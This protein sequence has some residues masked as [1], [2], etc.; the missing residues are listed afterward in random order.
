LTTVLSFLALSLGWAPFALAQVDVT[1]SAG[2]PATSYTTLKGA[3]DAINLGTHQG[4]IGI[5][6]TGST[7]ETAPAVLNAS[8]GASSYSAITIT[9]SGGAARTI[10]G[11]IVAGS[12]L[13][14]FNGA[15]NVTINGLNSGGNSL[16]IVNTTVSATSGTSTIRFIGGA[17]GNTIT[18]ANIQ[19]AGTSSVG[20]NGA[21]IFFSTDVNTANGN[22]NNTISNNNIGPVG[23]DLPTKAIL[24]NGSTTTTAIGNSGNIITNNN[25]FDFFG[26]ATTSSGVATNNGC[27]TWSI[28]NNRFYQTGTRT[29]STGGNHRVIDISG[30][31][32]TSGAQGFTI[33]GNIIGYASATQTG[34][35]TL[36]GSTGK[37]QGVVFNGI[38]AA[39]V[40]NVNANT[41]AS[42]SLSG[43]TSSGTSTSSPMIGIFI[44]SGLANTNNNIIGSQ[45]STGSLTFSTSTTT[46]TD[47]YGIYNF[48]IDSW[49]A[50]GNTIGGISVTNA[51][52]SGT[53]IIYGMRANT[54]T[55]VAFNSTSN[56]VGGAVA[57]SIQL[58]ATGI[59]SQVIG[60]QTS[61]AAANFSLN[62]IRNLTT[63]IGTGTS[64]AGS[65][66][67]INVTTTTPNHT[68][69]RNTISDLT[70]TNTTAA[71]VVTGIQFTGAAA[72]VVERNLITG[73]TVTTTSTAAE[74][75]GIRV[76]GG[77][78]VYRNNMIILG[79]GIANAIGTGST[80]GGV[81]GIN[82]PL[83]T[84][85]F[86]HNSV[87]IGGA[88]TAGAG[89][90]FAF[91][92]SQ[93]VN[94]RSFRNNIFLNGRSN[95]GATG[96]NYAVR[97]GGSGANPAGLTT[98]NNVYFANG[99]G[100]V[101][102]FYNLIDVANLAGWQAAI[103]QDAN[104]FEA[105]PLYLSTTDLRLQAGS[106][107]LDQAAN[108]AVTNDFEGDSRPG[109]NAAFDIGADERDGIPPAA[110]DLQ[111]TAFIDPSNGGSKLAGASFSPQASFTN[112]GTLG[113]T[114]VL[115]LFNLHSF[116]DTPRQTCERP[117]IL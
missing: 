37:F 31:A 16:T 48:G 19:G 11:A 62:T 50:S 36:T 3:F 99:T 72:N 39:T 66:I 10:S 90:S 22:D 103:A 116:G 56:T 55:S 108:L 83:G 57:N 80:T 87:F 85:S 82:A 41:V 101:F 35:Y 106:P 91:N 107:A 23:T 58:N 71:S 4:V 49:T 96:K 59:S 64:T 109:A 34:T 43:V 74:V 6:V 26:A 14:D 30:T 76:A 70:N 79:A 97:M 42:I 104:S 61:N 117:P 46:A 102:G 24:G 17:T 40:S 115:C 100:A 60:M 94:S 111:A 53:Q 1:A 12:P 67:G 7:T 78:T 73:L 98:N 112:N 44:A 114:N 68:L 113:Q 110:N 33:T 27:N 75:N 20:T 65:V 77:T 105:N 28:T 92:S 18:N 29:W 9:P 8:L 2:T 13:I 88:P 25:I 93:T 15:D 45:A 32:A 38:N 51:A 69:S 81:N 95:S 5:T 84:D 47:V 89:P 63:N 86:F 54:A 21:T 52:A